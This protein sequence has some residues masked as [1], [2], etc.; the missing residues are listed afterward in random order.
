M[1]FIEARFALDR[2]KRRRACGS[3]GMVRSKSGRRNEFLKRIGAVQKWF[4]FCGVSVGGASEKKRRQLERIFQSW[5]HRRIRAKD[6][7]M[8]SHRM[9]I[10]DFAGVTH[11]TSRNQQ[12]ADDIQASIGLYAILCGIAEGSPT[13]RW[14]KTL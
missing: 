5:R 3:A 10:A 12:A 13:Q 1:R 2:D 4:L 14:K 9:R 6:A 8:N 7:E 11:G